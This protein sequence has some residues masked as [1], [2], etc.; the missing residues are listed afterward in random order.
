MLERDSERERQR[1]RERE[2]AKERESEREKE[3]K[4]KERAIE[5]GF[6]VWG[7]GFRVSGL[8]FGVWGLGFGRE[9]VSERLS[10]S[11]SVISLRHK[12]VFFLVAPR[13]L[14]ARGAS[15]FII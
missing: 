12:P 14:R 11:V 13:A 9:R 5:R 15:F 6:R 2:R 10:V 7:L 4:R 3:R 1:E 8:G